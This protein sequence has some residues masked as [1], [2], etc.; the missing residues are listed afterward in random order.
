MNEAERLALIA[1]AMKA[2]ASSSVGTATMQGVAV[3]DLLT[4]VQMLTSSTLP[5]SRVST[6]HPQ[7]IFQNQNK[8]KIQISDYGLPAM[9]VMS[10]TT[11]KTFADLGVIMVRDL[12]QSPDVVFFKNII[13]EMDPGKPIDI[14]KIAFE[15]IGKLLQSNAIDRDVPAMANTCYNGIEEFRVA[16][17]VSE[18]DFAGARERLHASKLKPQFKNM[19]WANDDEKQYFNA[20]PVFKL[21]MNQ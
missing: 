8:K 18:P 6:E 15:C 14:T 4:V 16:L 11:T 17:A 2:I 10:L 3:G 5:R 19:L 9:R 13:D 21:T 1:A 12:V 7:F 20:T